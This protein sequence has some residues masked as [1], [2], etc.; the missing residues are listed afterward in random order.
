M[1][2]VATGTLEKQSSAYGEGGDDY[3]PFGLTFNSYTRTASTPQN[4]KYSGKELQTDLDLGWY[5]Y[6]FRMYDAAIGRW[7]VVDPLADK[8]NSVSPYNYVLNNPL[9]LIDL[10]GKDV[11]VNAKGKVIHDTGEGDKYF[12]IKTTKT[13]KEL[14]PEGTTDPGNSNPITKKEQKRALK[15]VSEG[16]IEGDHMSNFVELDDKSTRT[17]FDNIS[18]QDDS[19]GGPP[20]KN[21]QN[22]KEYGG[23]KTSKGIVRGEGITTFASQG[24]RIRGQWDMHSHPS[25]TASK[26]GNTYNYAQPP[27]GTDI[28]TAKGNETVIGR[29]NK[30]VYIYNS[31]GVIAIV[32]Q[33]YYVNPKK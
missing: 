21:V 2:Q 9:L 12:L 1:R 10:D 33:Q 29:G 20:T 13:T 18:K 23:K 3:Y 26:N 30:M 8:W 5:D 4:Y 24:G 16:N 17:E 6:G 32:P 11:Y 19:K 7:N 14:Y 25:G 28:N 15:L 22:N 27:S 31:T